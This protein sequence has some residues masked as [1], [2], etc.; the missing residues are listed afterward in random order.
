MKFLA[1][2][3]NLFTLFFFLII[4]L[5]IYLFTTGFNQNSEKESQKEEQVVE[6]EISNSSNEKVADGEEGKKSA[7]SITG[8]EGE[9]QEETTEKETVVETAAVVTPVNPYSD[10]IICIDPGHQE[11]ANLDKEPIGPGASE[12]KIKVT[13]GT[14]GVSTR[15]PEYKL[16]LEA[17]LM[18]GEL[19]EEK[20]FNVIYTRTTNDVNISNRER[21]DI[22]NK[23]KADLY[24][25]IHADGSTDKNVSGFAVLT[26][27][28]SNEYT[29]AIYAE[30][31]KAS[32]SIVEA[33]KKSREIKVNGISFRADLSGF[34][35]SEV[36]TTLVEM[37]YMTNP[38]EDEK[39]SNSDYLKNLITHIVDGITTYADTK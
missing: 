4:V 23:N 5:F 17:S 13:G 34:N 27:S 39:L 20:G 1:G 36:P 35:W 11:K 24:I 8:V 25:R 26:P 19:L 9:K 16:N 15:K 6:G 12:T 30:S 31:L 18:L 38:T 14:T 7:G 10:F 33:V 32:E 29:K 3:L 2:K 21:A 28:E 22:A 37:G